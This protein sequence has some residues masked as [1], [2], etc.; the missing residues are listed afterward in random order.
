VRKRLTDAWTA[1]QVMRFMNLRSLSN[2]FRSA[3]PGSITSVTKVFA[4]RHHQRLTELHAELA[5]PWLNVV[6]EDYELQPVQSSFLT[7]RSETIY[8]GTAEIQHN[9]IAERV[10]G[11]PK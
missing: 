4:S 6:G 9:I 1:I 3:D 2:L 5:G 10:L 11:L 8:G 7:S